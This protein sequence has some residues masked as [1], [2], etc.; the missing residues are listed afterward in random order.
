MVYGEH[1]LESVAPPRVELLPEQPPDRVA[2][3]LIRG[4]S[5]AARSGQAR[6]LP[7]LRPRR[8]R[9]IERSDSAASS[10]PA[11]GLRDVGEERRNWF[12][13][14]KSAADRRR[15]FPG[16]CGTASATPRRWPRR[17]GR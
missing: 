5:S 13:S 2:R 14:S 16:L 8:R 17:V 12:V 11:E 9:M 6:S 1:H 4:Y 15:R 3:C 10:P 7:N